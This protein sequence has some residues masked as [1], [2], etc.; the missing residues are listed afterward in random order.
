MTEPNTTAIPR[1][2]LVRSSIAASILL[3]VTC[4]GV[5]AWNQISL[6]GPMRDVIADDPRNA[7]VEVRVHLAGYLNPGVLVYD[8][9][10]VSGSSSP[11]DVFRVFLQYAEAM[12]DEHFDRVE[13][14]FR[15]KTKFVLDGADFREIGRER[16]DQ[17]PMYTIRTFPERLRK[18]DGSR[19]F[20]RREGPLLVV[21]ERQM[22]DFNEL[23][24]RWYLADL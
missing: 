2:R 9:R 4:T 14:A 17:N 23:Q 7:G 22:D 21:V 15:G 24:K 20:E 18:P 8:L 3:V 19:A 6:Q 5:F 13:L 10:E 16:A 1:R 11:I 12:R